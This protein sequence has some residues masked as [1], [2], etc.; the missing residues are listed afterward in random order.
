MAILE[1]D[2]RILLIPKPP[3]LLLKIINKIIRFTADEMEVAN[4]S[5][6]CC[7]PRGKAKMML[8]M[9]LTRMVTNATFTGVFVSCME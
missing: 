1:T 6:P 5:P 3:S 2:S 4:A 9:M 7:N 8:K